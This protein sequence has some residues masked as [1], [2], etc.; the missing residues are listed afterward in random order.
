VSLAGG[1]HARRVPR[2]QDL[3]IADTDSD[4]VAVE[5]GKPALA[6]LHDS[7]PCSLMRPD[8]FPPWREIET[9]VSKRDR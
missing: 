6:S 5:I 4:L 8:G 1:R 9:R 2:H 3:V 7:G